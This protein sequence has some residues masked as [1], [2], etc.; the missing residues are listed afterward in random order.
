MG[1]NGKSYMEINIQACTN[2]QNIPHDV[3][4]ADTTTVS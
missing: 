3:Y 1:I 4:I 2:G